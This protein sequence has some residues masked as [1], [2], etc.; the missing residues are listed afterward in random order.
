MDS[1]LTDQVFSAVAKKSFNTLSDLVSTNRWISDITYHKN[2]VSGLGQ[3][4]LFS[5][6]IKE[7]AHFVSLFTTHRFVEWTL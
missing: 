2:G 5:Q 3:G 6:I 1:F 4:S 7:L